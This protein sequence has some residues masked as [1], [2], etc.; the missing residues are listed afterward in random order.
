MIVITKMMMMM[1]MMI[2]I[3]ITTI[4]RFSLAEIYAICIFQS[5]HCSQHKSDHCSCCQN[6]L[7]AP[8]TPNGAI[9]FI[10][11]LR[12]TYGLG[13]GRTDRRTYGQSHDNQ[14]VLNRWVT[15]VLRWGL[16]EGAALQ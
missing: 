8:D 7:F 12:L 10:K 5:P 2:I 4:K 16:A 6:K 14:I 1:M 3:F 9:L 11:V 15:N 13:Y